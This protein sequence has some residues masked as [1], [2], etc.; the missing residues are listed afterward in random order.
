MC[1]GVLLFMS[2]NTPPQYPLP[3]IMSHTI[4]PLTQKKHQYTYVLI[5]LYFVVHP[6]S[7]SQATKKPRILAQKTRNFAQ[8][9]HYRNVVCNKKTM[10]YIASCE[11]GSTVSTSIPPFTLHPVSSNSHSQPNFSP[12]VILFSN[13]T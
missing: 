12:L 11:S 1:C 2:S 8:K 13:V 5:Y 9:N 3:H 10:R 4:A 7:T 6:L